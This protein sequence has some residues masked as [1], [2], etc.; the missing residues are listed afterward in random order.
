MRVAMKRLMMKYMIAGYKEQNAQYSS[1][2][3]GKNK[4]PKALIRCT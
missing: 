2:K 4:R 3:H 1:C